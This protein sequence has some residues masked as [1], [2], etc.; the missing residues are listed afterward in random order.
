VFSV[1]ETHVKAQ[2]LSKVCER[3]FGQWDWVSNIGQCNAGCRITI[4]WNR[5]MSINNV[6]GD[7]VEGSKIADA[8]TLTNEEVDA[9][10]N[11]V[12][13]QE[14]KA[15]M[16]SIDD[17]KAPSPDT[18]TACFFKKAWLVI[19][20]LKGYKIK[21]WSKRCALK[22]DIAKAYDTGDPISPYLFTLAMEVFTL[23]M[24]NKVDY[25]S[26]F[27]YHP[28]RKE[29]K[30][31]HFCFA[32]DLFVICHGS[33]ESLKVIKDSTDEFS[34]VSGLEPNM[35]KSTIFY[36]HVKMGDQRSILNVMPFRVGKFPVKY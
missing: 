23:I 20:L 25:S 21:G 8:F 22:I 32:D 6:V 29:L 24:A 14:I 30:L 10:V 36:G 15:T 9:M 27:K 3:V 31:T 4:G 11:D 35:S 2:K 12:S 1:I 26:V 7:V 13:D 19:E 28:R 34:R 33:E 16:F 5:V 18:Y 17:C